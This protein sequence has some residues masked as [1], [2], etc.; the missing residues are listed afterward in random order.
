[1]PDKV[2]TDAFAN[3]NKRLNEKG[4]KIIKFFCFVLA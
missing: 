4:K 1:M 3:Y 2:N